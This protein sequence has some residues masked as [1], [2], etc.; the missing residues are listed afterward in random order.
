MYNSSTA[1]STKI[2]Y[3]RRTCHTLVFA[4][5]P[6][7]MN[8]LS[9]VLGFRQIPSEDEPKGK[10]QGEQYPKQGKGVT[11]LHFIS[12]SRFRLTESHLQIER[13]TYTGT[14]FCIPTM[15]VM[16]SCVHTY[17]KCMYPYISGYQRG[18]RNG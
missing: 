5:R 9:S 13:P 4:I 2:I 15:L 10:Q 11:L 6:T 7:R 1:L 8:S 16:H 17:D 3:L 12:G 18:L 14:V